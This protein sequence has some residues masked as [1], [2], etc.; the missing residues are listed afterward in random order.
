MHIQ[1]HKFKYLARSALDNKQ[2]QENLKKIGT[3]FTALRN[4]A[5]AELEDPEHLL[6]AGCLCLPHLIAGAG[7][8]RCLG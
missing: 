6:I 3:T 4:Q 2:L 1:T 7:S 5:F 8:V